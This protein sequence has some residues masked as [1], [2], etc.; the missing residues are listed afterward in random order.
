M[1]I[2][3]FFDP[4]RKFTTYLVDRVSLLLI[5]YALIAN[6]SNISLAHI[7]GQ[8]SSYKPDVAFLHDWGLST[9]NQTI[10]VIVIALLVLT[11]ILEIHEK[12]LSFLLMFSPISFSAKTYL[13]PS[14]FD[15]YAGLIW[16]GYCRQLNLDEVQNLFQLTVGNI[17]AKERPHS[18]QT[19]LF[20][21]VPAWLFLLFLL[22]LFAP[23][24][25]GTAST[26]KFAGIAL[27]LVVVGLVWT[28]YRTSLFDYDTWRFEY[29]ALGALLDRKAHEFVDLS[30]DQ[31]KILVSRWSSSSKLARPWRVPIILCPWLSF[32]REATRYFQ[33]QIERRGQRT[34]FSA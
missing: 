13:G 26:G 28:L 4:V 2:P 15:T 33:N 11:A 25:I 3:N 5:T 30:E 22:Y 21:Y 17:R 10:L 14:S 1:D 24:S 27:M 9:D 18:V 23:A 8:N 32:A 19:E 31:S 20:D 34:R 16:K 6:L 29:I 12:L 7:Y